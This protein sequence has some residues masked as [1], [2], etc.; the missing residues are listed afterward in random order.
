MMQFGHLQNV[1]ATE[2]PEVV[3]YHVMSNLSSTEEMLSQPFECTKSGQKNCRPASRYSKIIG[4]FPTLIL[5]SSTILVFSYL[6]GFKSKVH[7]MSTQRQF[8]G[9]L[10]PS[11]L[12]P[13]SQWAYLNV[14]M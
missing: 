13:Y 5:N 2:M 12:T 11:E 10:K 6:C 7:C 4:V 8:P 1:V 3:F 14:S 9:N